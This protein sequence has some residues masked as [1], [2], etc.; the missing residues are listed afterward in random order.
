MSQ[1]RELRDEFGDE[2]HRLDSRGEA[3]LQ[4]ARCIQCG[5]SSHVSFRCT[6]CC[7]GH[8]LC[9]SCICVCHTRLPFHQIQVWFDLLKAADF[10][11]RF[12]RSGQ[13]V[14]SF[15]RRYSTSA[16]FFQW[17]TPTARL[18]ILLRL[19]LPSSRSSILTASTACAYP[20]AGASREPTIGVSSCAVDCGPPL[21]NSPRLWRPSTFCDTSRR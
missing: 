19:D 21:H 2:L 9:S 18:A 8:M 13:T 6:E 17:V 3:Y 7:Y 10:T 14:A 1:W 11:D 4:D 12:I 20:T 16:M 5:T 15:A